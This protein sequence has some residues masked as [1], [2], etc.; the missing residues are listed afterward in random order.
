[1]NLPLVFDEQDTAQDFY[2][3]LIKFC[4]AGQLNKDRF[5]VIINLKYNCKE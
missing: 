3:L 4:K 1:M 5:F 2:F